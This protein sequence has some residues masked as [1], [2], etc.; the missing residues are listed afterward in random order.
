MLN[1]AKPGKGLGK[2][3]GERLGMPDGLEVTGDTGVDVMEAVTE[4]DGVAETVQD[5]VGV[6]EGDAPTDGV[7]EELCRGGM[8]EVTRTLAA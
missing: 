8:Q 4:G 7:G 1:R 2:A 5:A 6:S 3:E